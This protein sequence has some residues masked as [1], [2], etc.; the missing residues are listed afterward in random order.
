MELSGNSPSDSDKDSPASLKSSD[1]ILGKCAP[2]HVLRTEVTRETAPCWSPVDIPAAEDFSSASSHRNK[3]MDGE[4]L[5]ISII[6][7]FHCFHQHAGDVINIALICTFQAISLSTNDELCYLSISSTFP[8]KTFC[9]HFEFP[10]YRRLTG[11]L[12]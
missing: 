2:M 11:S 6:S 5:P 7:V 8:Q 12:P 1:D 3:I 10:G 9:S 4:Y